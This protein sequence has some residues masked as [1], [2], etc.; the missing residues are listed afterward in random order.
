VLATARSFS[1]LGVHAEEVRVEVDVRSGLP[2][3]SI[4]GLPDAAVRESR[5]RVRAAV[6]NSGFEFPMR[7]ITVNLAPANLP[8]A[9]PGFDLAIA[10]A[11][12]AASG[13]LPESALE[14]L[15]LIGEVALDGRVRP[16]PGALPM[17][18]CARHDGIERLLVASGCAP[19]AALANLVGAN[20]NGNRPRPPLRVIAIDSLR[21]LGALGGSGALREVPAPELG[22]SG[23]VDGAPDLAELKGQPFLRQVLEVTAAGGHSL[24]ITG[25]PGAGKSMAARRLPTLLPPLGAGES[26]EVMRVASAA[27]RPVILD[28]AR[29]RPFRAPHHTISTAGLVGGGSPP[30][31]G[32]VTLAHRGVLFLDELPEFP[33]DALEALRQPLEDGRVAVARARYS[34]ELPC[35]FMLVAAANPCPCGHAAGEEGCDCAP[36]DI[37]RYQARL[38][39]ALAD[40]VDIVVTVEQPSAGD[41]EGP[42][43]EPSAAVRK[44][45]IAAR[46]RQER[47]LGPGRCNAEM[48]E[49]EIRRHCRLEAAARKRLADGHRRLQLS[50]RGYD[51]VIR[52]AR[53]I[54]DL[55]AAEVVGAEH[56]DG[57]LTMRRRDPE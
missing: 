35:E 54:A 31:P 53:T 51:R 47:R 39:G 50:A 18:E 14:G 57:A 55:A 24:L 16:V 1:L 44:R 30:R 34:V 2:S 43:G 21:E 29:R 11:L 9:G 22:S 56:V 7:R 5:E 48:G 15:A 20:G 25:P 6:A 37:R 26:I 42:L 28:E 17:A 13:E 12:L 46:R 8:K 23:A 3:F 4:V 40:R 49:G 27:G 32:E 45:V 41:L 19:E 10:T 52:V 36:G 38:S 33:R